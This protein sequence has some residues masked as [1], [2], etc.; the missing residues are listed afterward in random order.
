MQGFTCQTCGKHH[1]ELPLNYRTLAP[2]LWF[3]LP[4]SERKKRA[5]L[6]S[7]QCEIDKQYFFITGNIDIPILDSDQIFCWTVWVS[8]SANN[9]E[10]ACKKWQKEG[11]E[12]EP[13]CFGWLSTALPTYPDTLNL[14]TNVHTR[15]V[16]FRPNI[17]LEYSD[18]PLAI[19]QREGITWER[20]K[21]IAE[22]VYHQDFNMG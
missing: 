20:V 14:K 5:I 16:G 13:S 22:Y 12:S 3:T 7:D 15:P 18:H 10:R 8:L 11:R 2:A 21:E 17:E 9:Y 4:E 6:S 19:E 1:G